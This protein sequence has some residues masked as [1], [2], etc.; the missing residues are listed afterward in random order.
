MSVITEPA[1]M[2]SFRPSCCY[3]VLPDWEDAKTDFLKFSATV[4]RGLPML[5]RDWKPTEY[6]ASE[7][8]ADMLSRTSPF[9][10]LAKTY[11]SFSI[12]FIDW[13]KF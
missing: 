10:P 6:P 13:I 5:F 4:L 12:I 11:P 9:G 2:A 7:T 8:P 3:S 1:L